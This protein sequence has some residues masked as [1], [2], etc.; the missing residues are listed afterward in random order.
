MP[1]SSRKSKWPVNMG[2]KLGR[3]AVP[4]IG[5]QLIHLDLKNLELE[6]DVVL[7]LPLGKSRTKQAFS[8]ELS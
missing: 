6:E 2:G 3:I 1:C 4:S 5:E 8:V 7:A